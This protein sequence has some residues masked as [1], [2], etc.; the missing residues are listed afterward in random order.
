M[1]FV[2]MARKAYIRARGYLLAERADNLVVDKM[3]KKRVVL[4]VSIDCSGAEYMLAYQE[5][6]E[7]TALPYEIVAIFTDRRDSS[8]FEVARRYNIPIKLHDIKGFC[9]ESG[10][11]LSDLSSRP[12]YFSNVM[13][14]LKPYSADMLCLIDYDLI[15]TEPLLG[16][17][18]N[19][20]LSMH[21]ADLSIRDK[22]GRAIYVGNNSVDSAILS[23]ATELRSTVHFVTKE[24]DQGS[25]I[26]IS[27]PL[28]VELPS[29][30]SV[31]ELKLQKNSQLLKSIVA[32]HKLRLHDISLKTYRVALELVASG[33]ILMDK[34]GTACCSDDA[35]RISELHGFRTFGLRISNTA[36]LSHKA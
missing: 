1:R 24:L 30:I 3:S 14:A 20:I 35:L 10:T 18:S 15:I 25:P 29:G 33:S 6:H 21:P 22:E 13:N 4:F 31:N 26:L 12:E 23:G 11:E 9:A 32:A 16:S 2:R 19:R 28:R 17:H 8:A 27:G 5:A 7:D 34:N 36:I